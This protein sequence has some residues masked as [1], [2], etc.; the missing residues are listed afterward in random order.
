MGTRG[1][2][3]SVDRPVGQVLKLL[4]GDTV[5]VVLSTEGEITVPASYSSCVNS[6]G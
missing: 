5:V 6:R 1:R 4:T 2:E 3:L